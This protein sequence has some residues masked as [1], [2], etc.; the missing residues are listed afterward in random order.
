MKRLDRFIGGLFILRAYME[1]ETLEPS[2]D[3]I[4]IEVCEDSPVPPDI[5][6]I[7]KNQFHWFQED[8]DPS[9]FYF[10]S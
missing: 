3:V 5:V 1:W 10:F 2:H 8:D 6:R 9:Q 4:Y 7:L